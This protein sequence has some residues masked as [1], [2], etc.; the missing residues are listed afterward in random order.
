LGE[1]LFRGGPEFSS[2]YRENTFLKPKL[3]FRISEGWEIQ[4][5]FNSKGDS[6]ATQT[7]QEGIILNGGAPKEALGENSCARGWKGFRIWRGSEPCEGGFLGRTGK[8]GGFQNPESAGVREAQRGS[9]PRGGAVQFKHLLGANNL[10]EG[11]SGK[12]QNGV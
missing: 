5:R 6:L 3:R 11:K 2:N 8:K 4:E 10:G 12:G 7:T 9:S 1:K